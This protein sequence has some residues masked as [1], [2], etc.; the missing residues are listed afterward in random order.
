MCQIYFS[1]TQLSFSFVPQ[2]DCYYI[3]N[4][5]DSFFLFLLH[6]DFDIFRA[7]LFRVFLCVFDN[8]YFSFLYLEKKFI[9]KHFY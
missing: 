6:K 8:I 9:K 2:K 7:L 3:H 5:T 4:D 1:Y